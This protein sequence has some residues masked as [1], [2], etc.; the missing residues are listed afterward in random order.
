MLLLPFPLGYDLHKVIQVKSELLTDQNIRWISY[1]LLV[2][3]NY[4][5][6]AEVI[7]RDL[8]VC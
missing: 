3:L 8:K 4:L 6:S 1:Q 5:H 2:A 7:H